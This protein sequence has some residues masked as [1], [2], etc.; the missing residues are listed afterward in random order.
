VPRTQVPAGLGPDRYPRQDAQCTQ[1][2]QRAHRRRLSLAAAPIL[3]RSHRF[4]KMKPRALCPHHLACFVS[5]HLQSDRAPACAAPARRL[6]RAPNVDP[7]RESSY[8]YHG[9]AGR[10]V[11]TITAFLRHMYSLS[12][13]PSQTYANTVTSSSGFCACAEFRSLFTAAQSAC[14]SC[15]VLGHCQHE[16]RAL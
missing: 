10:M 6:P 5:A 11:L 8:Q 4:L 16:Q 7:D 14:G 15:A 3:K 1:L 13:S 12:R 2:Q 9:H